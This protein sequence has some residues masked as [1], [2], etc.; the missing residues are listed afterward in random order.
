MK[1]VLFLVIFL[2][3][4]PTLFA[5]GPKRE[6]RGVW[7]A[8]VQ[9]IDWPSARNYNG[10]K[11]KEEFISLLNSHQKTGFNAIF[12]QVRTASDAFYAKSTEPWTSFLSGLQGQAPTPYYDPMEFMIQESH[13][14]GLEFHAWLNLNRATLSSKSLLSSDHIARKHPEW[15][16]LYNG[17]HILNFGMPQVRNYI[18][19]LVRNLVKNYDLDGIHFDDYFYPYPAKNAKLN[20]EKTYQTFKLLDENINDWRRRNVNLLIKQISETIKETKPK[21]KFGISPFGIWKHQSID[22]ENGSPTKNGLQS[23]HD[24][25]ADTDLWMKSNWV[26][27]LAPQLYWPLSHRV[28]PFEP[29]AK[30]WDSHSYQR[31]IYVGYAAYHLNTTWNSNELAKQLAI[32]RGLNKVTGAIYFSSNLLTSNAKGWRDSL[33]NNHFAHV[34]LVPTMTWL[35][36][37]PPTA[38]HQVSLAKRQGKWRLKWEDGEASSDDDHAEYYVVYRIKKGDTEAFEKAENII[39]KGKLKD[40]EIENKYLVTGHGFAVTALDRLHNESPSGTIQW[41]VANDE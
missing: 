17:Q 29:L 19:E 7:V 27:Y 10:F 4:F 25:F 9:N 3:S 13:E 18:A 38:P 35:D 1:S 28:A 11:Q 22:D 6:L 32:S 33:R 14:R 30:W 41:I 20:D 40:I 15:L 12:V 21:V 23:Y 8:T 37:I 34:A 16:L 24:L 2:L 5:K 36:S 31:P 26:D 39:Y